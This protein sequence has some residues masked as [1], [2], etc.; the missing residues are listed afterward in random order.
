MTGVQTC[1]LPISIVLA[2]AT[3]GRLFAGSRLALRSQYP[4]LVLMVTYTMVSLWILA[5]PVVETAPG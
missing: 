2:H 4:L 1:A 3:A 5:Q